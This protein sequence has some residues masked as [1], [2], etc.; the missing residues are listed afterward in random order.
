MKFQELM[1][2]C[3][4]KIPTF[5]RIFPHITEKKGVSISLDWEVFASKCLRQSTGRIQNGS[6]TFIHTVFHLCFGILVQYPWYFSRM[7]YMCVCVCECAHAF[8]SV[9]TYVACRTSGS[10]WTTLGIQLHLPS[11]LRQGISFLMFT[12]LY[13]RPTELWASR[14]VLCLPLI[15]P[16]E[17]WDL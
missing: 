5:F 9:G 1:T 3:S 15:F 16:S 17:C 10:H 8:V 4:W 14:I 7:G 11:S 6:T 13:T 2:D 12:K